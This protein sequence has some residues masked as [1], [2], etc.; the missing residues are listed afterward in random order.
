MLA[1]SADWRL[2]RC[3]QILLS[4][5]EMFAGPADAKNCSEHI[6]GGQIDSYSPRSNEDCHNGWINNGLDV[7]RQAAV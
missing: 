2:S 3:R 4:D 7:L 6:D 5:K 1:N